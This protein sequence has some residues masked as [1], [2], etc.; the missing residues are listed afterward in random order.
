MRARFQKAAFTF[1]AVHCFKKTKQ[2]TKLR[3]FALDQERASSLL[4]RKVTSWNYTKALLCTHAFPF[5]SP[6]IKMEVQA[7]FTSKWSL[8][9]TQIILVTVSI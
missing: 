8:L 1:V 9:S 7:K 6:Q 2:N 3:E 5:G 4:Y